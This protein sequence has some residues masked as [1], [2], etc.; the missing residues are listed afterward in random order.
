VYDRVHLV[1]VH[2]ITKNAE[3]LG[4]KFFDWYETVFDGSGTLDKRDRLLIALACSLTVQC[5]YCIDAY[6]AE[7]VDEGLDLEEMSEALHVASA[8]RAGATIMHGMQ[9][10]DRALARKARTQSG[11][12]IQQGN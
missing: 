5:P 12:E 1:R 4:T 2:E 8:I 7:C 10:R 9:M 6:S 3:L 11:S